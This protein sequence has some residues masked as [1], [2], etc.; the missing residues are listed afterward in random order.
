MSR[1]DG[2]GS[3]EVWKCGNMEVVIRQVGRGECTRSPYLLGTLVIKY[4]T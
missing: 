1:G 4:L 2:G 3:V